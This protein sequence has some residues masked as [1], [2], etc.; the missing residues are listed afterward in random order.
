MTS[1]QV[2]EFLRDDVYPQLKGAI[3]SSLS[4]KEK[5]AKI[6]IR[7]RNYGVEVEEI[8]ENGDW[9]LFGSA[10]IIRQTDNN[11]SKTD[12][13]VQVEINTTSLAI[14]CYKLLVTRQG[15]VGTLLEFLVQWE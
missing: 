6:L 4:R 11:I 3:E 15:S 2:N 9:T 5:S 8:L 10:G 7:P 12:N 14:P 13:G 1:N